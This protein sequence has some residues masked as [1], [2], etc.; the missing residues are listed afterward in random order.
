MDF[1]VNRELLVIKVL[2]IGLLLAG[3]GFTEKRPSLKSYCADSLR[4]QNKNGVLFSGAE[5][6][7]GKLY[8]LTHSGDSIFS[9]EYI[10]GQEDG[11]QKLW[12][13]NA[14]LQEI[15]FYTAGKKTGKHTG[16]W[17]DG[18][19]RFQYTYSRDIY[20]GTQYEWFSNGR[21]C[22]KKNYHEGYE[23][24][25]QQSWTPDGAIKS[26]YEAR[27]GRNYGNIGKKSCYSVWT[28]SAF[29]NVH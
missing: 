11:I 1:M 5:P 23:N 22:S 16:Y 4:L 8:A 25:L 19:K 2:I 14:A 9:K 20:E 15:R 7:T 27:N 17:P 10:M 3:C 28:D 26:N 6:F 12:Y 18:R 21:L 24:S 29:V 13:P